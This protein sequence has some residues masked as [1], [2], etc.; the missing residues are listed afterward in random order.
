MHRPR[1]KRMTSVDDILRCR[2]MLIVAVAVALFF[3]R[4]SASKEGIE[5]GCVQADGEEKGL[6]LRREEE[7]ELPLPLHME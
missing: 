6:V 2:H 3:H 5:A 1:A 4:G 7:R